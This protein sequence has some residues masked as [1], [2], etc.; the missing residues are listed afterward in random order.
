MEF[1]NLTQ[2][3]AL[4]FSNIVLLII[5]YQITKPALRYPYTLT[6]Q[7]SKLTIILMGAFC[8]FSFW[9]ADWFGYLQ[10]Y[11]WAKGEGIEHVPMEE[12]YLWL[13]ENVSSYIMFRLV[14]WG[15]ALIALLITIK[16]LKIQSDLFLCFFSLISL[17]WFSYARASLAMSL[18]FCGVSFMGLSGTYATRK[19]RYILGICLIAA[20][21]YCHKSSLLGIAAVII[22]ILLDH[23]G[24]RKSIKLL[25]FSFPI[26]VLIVQG[27]FSTILSDLLGAED[28]VIGNYAT[29]GNRY[30]ESNSSSHGIG[31][32]LEQ[33]LERLPAYL[34]SYIG[35]KAVTGTPN[36]PKE[37]RLMIYTLCSMVFVSSIFA[38]DLGANTSTVYERLLRYTQIPSCICLTYFY[39]NNI[40]PTLTKHTL[41][42]AIFGTIYT[43][44]YTFYNVYVG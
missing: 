16:N 37:I 21:F 27:L 42:I 29:A 22:A 31:I 20:S 2:T 18:M 39:C 38:F 11:I 24:G 8:L 34:L 32:I 6:R 10:Y 23:Y 44:L 41:R 13:L 35:L 12:V 36:I 1:S 4:V 43:M 40:Y 33:L 15:S 25:L 19:F 5:L 28:T 30:L 14:V 7:K 17:I 26:A 3:P 9:G